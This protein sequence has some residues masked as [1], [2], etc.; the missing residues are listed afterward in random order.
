MA[1]PNA[2]ALLALARGGGH[3]GVAEGMSP[4]MQSWAYSP[5][6]WAAVYQP[7]TSLPRA[8]DTF[9]AGQFGPLQ[10]LQ[11]FPID[12]GEE[13][14]GRPRPRRWQYPVAF[15][16]IVGAP[17][18]EGLMLATYQQ[19]EDYAEQPSVLR[20]LIESCK[21]DILNLVKD[22]L[23]E[24]IIPTPAAAK[25][26][27]GSPAKRKDF[28]VRKDEVV[29]FFRNPDPGGHSSSFTGWLSSLVEDNLVLDAVA[30]H[31]QPTSKAKAGP[32]GS[33]LAGLA[34]IS[35]DMIKPLIDMHG[36]RPLP[37]QPAY[38]QVVWGVPRVDLMDLLADI[39]P[40]STIDDMLALSPILEQAMEDTD[41][42]GADQLIFGVQNRRNR[43]VYGYSP[44][45]QALLGCSIMFARQLWQWEFF[46]SGSLPTVF[47][48]PG[49]TV[50]T[51]EEARQLQEAINMLGGDL[52]SRHQVIVLPP[53]SQVHDQKPVDLTAQIDEWLVALQCMSFGKSISDLGITPKVAAMQSPQASRGAAQ[54]ASDRSTKASTIPRAR[55]FIDQVLNRV[56][57]R[58]L[59]QKDMTWTWGIEEGGETYQDKV[60]QEINLVKGLLSSIDESRQ[61]LGWDAL[62]L[63]ETS[64]PVLQTTTGLIPV[65]SPAMVAAA[66]EPAKPTPP[67]GPAA[68]LPGQPPTK[69]PVKEPAKEPTGTSTAPAESPS[70]A[71]ARAAEAADAPHVP[72]ASKKVYGPAAINAE[73][74][75]LRRYLR[76]GRPLG[77]FVGK[78][79]PAAALHAGAM[80]EGDDGGA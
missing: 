10:P 60:A 74:E 23:S 30:V 41:R 45:M 68:L 80:V 67:A 77:S 6:G 65:G 42:F 72:A 79:L 37:P 62:G 11:D 13:P 36:G 4:G 28:E 24:N 19:V 75:I 7:G 59:G 17:G 20:A 32:V 55:F 47:L 44:A 29:D 49:E 78:A 21:N 35:G 46:R 27:Q 51:A 15:N 71:G 48:D 2:A 58:H 73:C 54:V 69:P 31:V 57:Q 52:G 26:M 5:P 70:H 64:V 33:S 14:S 16:V 76:K 66:E 18:T 34:P 53:G 43:S 8:Y 38:Q 39:G 50:A 1:D 9:S 25:A 61:R 63:P 12:I 3:S 40:T 22:D 56:I